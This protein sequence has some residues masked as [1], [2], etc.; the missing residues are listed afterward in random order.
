[1]RVAAQLSRVVLN[2]AV[3]EACRDLAAHIDKSWD[4]MPHHANLTWHAPRDGTNCF[5]GVSLFRTRSA[6]PRGFHI[7]ELHDDI[8]SEVL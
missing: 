6:E 8:A 3:M 5:S 1:M 2:A 7:D 4:R